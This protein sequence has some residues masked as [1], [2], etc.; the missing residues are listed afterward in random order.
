MDMSLPNDILFDA[1]WKDAH[2]LVFLLDGEGRLT[3]AN[4]AFTRVTGYAVSDLAGHSP[5]QV[6]LESLRDWV[7]SSCTGAN[8]EAKLAFSQEWITKKGYVV[9]VEWSAAPFASAAGGSAFLCT[10]KA[11]S[12]E[13]ITKLQKKAEWLSRI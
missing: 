11:V 9:S 1:I 3:D 10:G 5:G 12:L 2:T 6:L 7:F 13:K 4:P 8:P